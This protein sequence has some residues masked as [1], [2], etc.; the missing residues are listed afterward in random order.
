MS[1]R[2]NVC[3]T[4]KLGEKGRIKA[5]CIR[6]TVD[7]VLHFSDAAAAQDV[8]TTEA[9]S[10]RRSVSHADREGCVR[11]D[12]ISDPDAAGGLL[13]SQPEVASE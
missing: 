4:V 3:L 13:P 8:A 9:L 10:P 5:C 2:E 7:L 12:N 6:I 11:R 1:H